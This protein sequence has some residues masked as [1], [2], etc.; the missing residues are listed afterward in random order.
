MEANT[1]KPRVFFSV[2][3]SLRGLAALGVV[4][5]HFAN[6]TLPTVS[7][8]FFGSQ[9]EW[10]RQG[11][12]LFFVI[13]GFVIPYSMF[14]AKYELRDAGRYFLKRMVR[15][16][17][18]AWIAILMIICI[19]MAG[20]LINGRP[21]QGMTWP[22]FSLE[23]I[24]A[25]FLFSFVLF[26]VEK[27][28][29]V[30]WTLEVEFQF[31]LAIALIFPL[32]IRYKDNK[33]ILSI[34]FLALSST[35]FLHGERVLFFKMNS[36]FIMGM[37]LFMYKAKLVDRNYFVGATALASI[38]C[39]L[40]LGQAMACASV[41]GVLVIGL[42]DF[43]NPV[44]DFLGMISFSLY[45]THHNVGVVSEYLLRNISGMEPS[46]PVKFIMFF[47][48]LGIAIAFAWIFHR[49]VEKPFHKMSQR[50]SM[51]RKP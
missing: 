11:I 35:F 3:E 47:V 24:G 33:W 8:I 21:I 30:Y 39:Y 14:L 31:Y 6:G 38:L 19:Y 18:P 25:N 41:I 32:L 37:L 42:V 50:I 36:Y 49:F 13:S 29:E 16:A 10:A 45:I 9:M 34:V 20:L 4:A 27:F 44:L 22:G 46:Q 43:K 40:Q 48:Y 23:S 1:N 28:I 7:P 26:D 17:P 2:I 12:P 5:Y 15:M 51:K